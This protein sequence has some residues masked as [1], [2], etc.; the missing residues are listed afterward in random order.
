[1]PSFGELLRRERELRQIS[2][3]EI[4][5]A[6]KINLRYLEALERND[7]RHLPG[8]VFNKGFVRAYAQFIGVDPERMINA[9]LVEERDQSAAGPA[10]PSGDVLRGRRGASAEPVPP[11]AKARTSTGVRVAVVVAVLVALAALV[12]AVVW[13]V[14]GSDGAG[15]PSEPDR[16]AAEASAPETPGTGAA[17][18][19]DTPDQG[20]A[21]GDGNAPEPSGSE[22]DEAT[23]SAATRRPDGP[24]EA[25]L[26]LVREVSG[27]V[28]CDRRVDVLDG[29]AAGTVLRLTC[30]DRLVVE[31]S[32]GGGVVVALDG[33]PARPIGLDRTA[34]AARDLLRGDS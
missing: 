28:V 9:Y 1:M 31:A 6:T 8:G 10:E 19:A 23:G 34:V 11:K 25:V 18:P 4:S 26:T 33:A 12:A 15:T 2:L 27:R 30:R 7:F 20:P 29:R 5:E 16:P 24:H 14:R 32:D 22:P 3:R 21:A 13:L 17:D